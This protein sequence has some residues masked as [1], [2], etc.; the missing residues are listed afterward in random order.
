VNKKY[1]VYFLLILQNIIDDRNNNKNEPLYDKEK[2]FEFILNIFKEIF[3]SHFQT[4][5]LKKLN[6]NSSFDEKSLAAYFES[7][8]LKF[9]QL[10]RK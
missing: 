3:Q 6:G 2:I 1:G 4:N 10:K 7:F 5:F 9:S 8:Y